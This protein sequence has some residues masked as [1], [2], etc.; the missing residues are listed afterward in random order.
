MWAIKNVIPDIR[1]KGYYES[2]KKGKKEIEKLN[3]TIEHLY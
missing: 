1:K 3:K 2:N